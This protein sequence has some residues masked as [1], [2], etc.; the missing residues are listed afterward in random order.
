MELEDSSFAIGKE[1][2]FKQQLPTWGDVNF[3]SRS[4]VM[5]NGID[6]DTSKFHKYS[7]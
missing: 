1:Y 7:Y 2:S 6:Y 3:G 5:K 4:R